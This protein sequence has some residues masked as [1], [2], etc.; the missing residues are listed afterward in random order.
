MILKKET[1]MKK[2]IA[3]G[4]VLLA[5]LSLVSCVQIK[6]GVLSAQVDAAITNGNFEKAE[7]L[8]KEIS[9]LQPKIGRASWWERV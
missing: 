5:S 8:C 9:A 3:A 2:M 7:K 1:A 4:I 6:A